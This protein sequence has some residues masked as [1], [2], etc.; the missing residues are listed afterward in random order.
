M[1]GGLTIH[2]DFAGALAQAAALAAPGD[3]VVPIAGPQV[4]AVPERPARPVRRRSGSGGMTLAELY[5]KFTNDP[6]R[7]HL[8]ARGELHYRLP[9]RAL[10]E[11]LGPDVLVSHITRDDCRR[12]RDIFSTLPTGHKTRF[13]KLTLIEASALG[14]KGGVRILSR[15]TANGYLRNM[16]T[17]FAWAVREQYMTSNP[18]ERLLVPGKHDKAKDLRSSFSTAQLV[19]IFNAPLYTG[20]LNDGNGYAQVGEERPRRGRFWAPLLSLWTGMRLQEC[21]QL[22]VEDVRRVDGVDV[23][24]VTAFSESTSEDTQKRVKTKAGERIIPLH[25]ELRRIGF[26]EHVEKMRAASTASGGRLFPELERGETGYYSE[27]FSKWFGRFL[28]SV[29][30][31]TPKTSFHSFRHAFRDALREANIPGERVRVLAGWSSVRI[32]DTYGSGFRPSTLYRELR[33]IEYPGLSLRHLH[34][35]QP[36]LAK[37]DV[38]AKGEGG[39]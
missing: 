26:L 10:R 30:A 17:M 32:S 1:L 25:P 12:V 15:N 8:M 36:D 38:G 4:R 9:L 23:I 31:K 16:S 35:D 29:N 39:R 14:A 6:A 3:N 34:T 22:L 33:K 13:P 19:A 27:V 28:K 2:D 20:C 18:A 5:E 24:A 11:L 37:A 7:S 21:C